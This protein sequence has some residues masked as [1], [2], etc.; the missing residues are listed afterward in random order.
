MVAKRASAP[1][2][3]ELAKQGNGLRVIRY[4]FKTK[5]GTIVARNYKLGWV[6][7]GE[8]TRQ[9]DI[10]SHHWRKMNGQGPAGVVA[11]MSKRGQGVKGT[12]L[13]P[14]DD[15]KERQRQA[16]RDYYQRTK[17]AK[18]NDGAVTDADLARVQDHIGV[19]VASLGAISATVKMVQDMV[20]D[21]QRKRAGG[22]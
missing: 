12:A 17:T 5:K 13:V 3:P 10:F 14:V 18:S 15:K 4:P 19:I 1:D 16:S 9:F 2:K 22:A 20:T 6:D 7:D 11:K 21:L 8:A